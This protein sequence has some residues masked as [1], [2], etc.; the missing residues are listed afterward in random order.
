MKN[1]KIWIIGCGD[2]GRRVAKL[3]TEAGDYNHALFGIVQSDKSIQACQN[4]GI[5]AVRLD[6]DSPDS[7]IIQKRLAGQ[8][9]QVDCFYFAPPPALGE[10]DTRLQNFLSCLDKDNLPRRIV[11]ISTTGVYGDSEGAWIDETALLKPKADRAKRRLS[12]ENALQEW[13]AKYKRDFIILRVPGIYATDRLPL[14]RLKKGLPV[15]NES[16]AGWT[17]RI[18]ADDLAEACK[19]AMSCQDTDQIIN[20]TDGNPSTMTSYF[21]QVADFANLPRPSSDFNG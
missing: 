17:N 9:S 13:S 1:K 18:H 3:Y 11:L 20:V 10:T 5:E 15:V 4:N 14:E 19:A 8:F 16:E 12:A 7:S 21:N 6:L 2:I